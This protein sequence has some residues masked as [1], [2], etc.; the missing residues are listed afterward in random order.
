MT[1]E[2]GAAG[3]L[4]LRSAFITIRAHLP[5]F[6][7]RDRRLGHV[8]PSNR[9]ELTPSLAHAW[10][11]LGVTARTD[12][13]PLTSLLCY[14]AG[15][16]PRACIETPSWPSEPLPWAPQCRVSG[17]TSLRAISD[18]STTIRS[19]PQHVRAR[20]SSL[21]ASRRPQTLQRQP[22][23]LDSRIRVLEIQRRNRPPRVLLRR[24]GRLVIRVV[25]A[26]GRALADL[27]RCRRRRR[28]WRR[29]WSALGLLPLLLELRLD[30]RRRWLQPGR[31]GGR[32][33]HLLGWR[34]VGTIGTSYAE[35]TGRGGG[36]ID[37]W[38]RV[39]VAV[40]VLRFG[41]WSLRRLEG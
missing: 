41:W 18:L 29:S 20:P 17:R 15:L 30:V 23:L 24:Q 36:W 27:G 19:A 37:E 31:G 28:S 1:P 9:V 5:S 21:H 6:S 11:R 39:L 3:P 33:R 8:S 12:R 38:R 35:L 13:C 25:A 16:E 2:K 14:Q 7:Q 40:E 10:W 26:R 34:L 22:Q 32:W 4:M